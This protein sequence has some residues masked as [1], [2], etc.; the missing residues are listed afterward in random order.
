[1]TAPKRVCVDLDHTL[2][3]PSDGPL[4]GD[5]YP[6]ARFFLGMLQR[7]GIEIVIHTA[8]IDPWKPTNDQMG[9]VL[10]WL[11]RHHLPYDKICGKPEAIAYIDDRA[12]A[13]P[14]DPNGD[15]YEG[16]FRLIER[17]H[18]EQS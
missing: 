10:G 12:I 9:M 18:G 1:M 6:G 4:P 14:R 15:F 17:L 2:A 13:V 8:R 5:P 11:D 7:A 16:V 3:Q